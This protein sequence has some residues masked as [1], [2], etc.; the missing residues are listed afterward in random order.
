M[1]TD[2]PAIPRLM[3][4]EQHILEGERLH[5]EATGEFSSILHNIALAAKLVWREATKAGQRT[6]LYIGS[7]EEVKLA[8]RFLMAQR[9]TYRTIHA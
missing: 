1:I 8:E 7:K 5:P 6:P 2:I 3:T 9:Q 4:L